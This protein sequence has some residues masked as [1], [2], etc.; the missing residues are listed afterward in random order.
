MS[1]YKYDHMYDNM[2]MIF[3]E[4]QQE[5]FVSWHISILCSNFL[6]IK[7]DNSFI[8]KFVGLLLKHIT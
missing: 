8:I 4:I 5:N 2:S 1:L 3:L 6:N 7:I